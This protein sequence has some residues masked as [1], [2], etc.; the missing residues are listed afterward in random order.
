MFALVESG[1][2]TKFF[3][4]N[5]GINLNNLKYP[6]SIFT[7]W[8]K[9]EREAIGIYEVI[10]DNTNKKDEKWYINTNVSYAFGSGKVTASYGSATAKAHADT[11]Y[12]EQ[13]KTDDKIPADKDVGDVKNRGLKY[14]LIQIV[15]SQAAAN[16]SDTDWYVI[17]KADAGTAVPSAITNHRAAVRTKAAE[18]ETAITNAADTPALETLY[19]YVNTAD[20]GDPVVMERPLGELP[21]L[22]S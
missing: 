15:K 7:L 1:S 9:S 11:L 10:W 21:R 16:L 4:G 19:T 20:E 22:E 5:K 17:R 6:K 12:T 13:D 18:M 8:T 14:N 2:I 3:S